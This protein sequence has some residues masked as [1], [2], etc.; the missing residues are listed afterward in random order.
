MEH[1][2]F[3]W[4]YLLLSSAVGNRCFAVL[5]FSLRRCQLILLKNRM[6]AATSFGDWIDAAY[7]YDTIMVRRSRPGACAATGFLCGCLTT[8][9]FCHIRRVCAKHPERCCRC[10]CGD[11]TYTAHGVQRRP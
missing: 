10:A 9:L 1:S 4:M 11:V 2:L 6:A 7:K 8:R 5:L 3:V